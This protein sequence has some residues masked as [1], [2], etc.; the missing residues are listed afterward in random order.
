MLRLVHQHDPRHSHSMNKLSKTVNLL[1]LQSDL[2]P[3][4]LTVSTPSTWVKLYETVKPR[5]VIYEAIKVQVS[6]LIIT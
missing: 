1:T 5:P 3:W 6:Y 2:W 4:L